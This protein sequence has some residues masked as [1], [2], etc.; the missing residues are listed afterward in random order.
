MNLHYGKV[1][2][3]HRW[4]IGCVTYQSV[5]ASCWILWCRHTSLCQGNQGAKV[6]L[7]ICCGVWKKRSLRSP[8]DQPAK[9]AFTC[10]IF[11]KK[12]CLLQF[13]VT[14]K[15]VEFFHKPMDPT[16]ETKES[17][18]V[19]HDSTNNIWIPTEACINLPKLCSDLTWFTYKYRDFTRAYR[20]I[21]RALGIVSS[22]DWDHFPGLAWTCL[23]RPWTG[24]LLLT[25]QNA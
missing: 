23:D 21:T 19:N 7:H 25:I 6:P 10:I 9:L 1:S 4:T 20:N 17:S 16:N 12:T 13:T 8:W 24:H 18:K 22:C 15:T 3:E 14:H 11:P 5:T 2:V